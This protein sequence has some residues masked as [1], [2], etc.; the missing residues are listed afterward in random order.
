MEGRATPETFEKEVVCPKCKRR[1]RFVR[2]MTEDEMFFEGFKKAGTFAAGFVKKAVKFGSKRISQRRQ[3]SSA[4][5]KLLPRLQEHFRGECI[6]KAAISHMRQ[7]Y[8]P[9]GLNLKREMIPLKESFEAFMRREARRVV[10]LGGIEPEE[11]EA[12]EEYLVAFGADEPLVSSVR[13][14]LALAEAIQKVESGRAEP[15]EQVQG[16]AVR[17]SEIV[18]YEMPAVLVG[19]SRGNDA[20]EHEGNLYITNMRIVFTS[21]SEPRETDISNVNAVENQAD[22]LYVLG[23][24]Q[25]A[26]N[27]FILNQPELAAAHIRHAVRVYHRQTDVGFERPSRQITQEVKQAVWQRDGGC[28]VECGATDYLEFDHIIPYSR[29]G[30]NTVDNV[31]LLCRRCNLKKSD[32][33]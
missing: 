20:T 31:Q 23:K 15:L 11:K 27:E 30:A 24:T 6:T 28:C 7:T 3:R 5:K 18:W 26:S 8:E 10:A 16:L 21:R 32:R 9:L 29:G 19:R 33:L 22:T 25:R 1:V 4:R 12:F 2:L 14:N 13:R 17:N